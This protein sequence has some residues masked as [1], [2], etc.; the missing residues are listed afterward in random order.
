[1]MTMQQATQHLLFQLYHIYEQRE[2]RNIADLVMEN[3]TEWKKIDRI[4][5]K[6]R[7]TIHA[8]LS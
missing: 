7:L 2:A 4:L 1:M 3:I 5:Y 6:E 8:S